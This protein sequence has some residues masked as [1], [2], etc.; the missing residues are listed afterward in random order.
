MHPFYSSRWPRFLQV[1]RMVLVV[2]MM[3]AIFRLPAHSQGKERPMK[4]PTSY[5][6]IQID[7]LSLFYREA[8]PK[9]GPTLL[10]LHG[11]P[12]S[13]RMFEPLFSPLSDR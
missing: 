2:S 1:S 13:S 3:L 9:D 4:Q 12:S 5:R 7:G 10:L 11:L 8:G 6:T